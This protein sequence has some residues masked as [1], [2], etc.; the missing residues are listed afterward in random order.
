MNIRIAKKVIRRAA[1]KY[2]RYS[3]ACAAWDIAHRTCRR[4]SRTPDK[5]IGYAKYV[6]LLVEF[7]GRPDEPRVAGRYLTRKFGLYM[8]I[9]PACMSDGEALAI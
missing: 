2:H 9:D 8:T 3:T 4:L 1:G 7:M 5:Y 6:R